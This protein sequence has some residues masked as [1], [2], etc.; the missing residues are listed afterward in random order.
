MP[1]IADWHSFC[2]TLA[3]YDAFENFIEVLGFFV[4]YRNY[5]TASAF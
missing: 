5:E 3:L 4:V 1:V 2:V